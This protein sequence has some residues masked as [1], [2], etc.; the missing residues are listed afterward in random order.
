VD[1]VHDCDD[2]DCDVGVS[3]ECVRDGVAG[4]A[5]M[6][7]NSRNGCVIDCE[8]ENDLHHQKTHIWAL[9]VKGRLGKWCGIGMGSS[10]SSS[11]SRRSDKKKGAAKDLIGGST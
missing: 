6:R 2:D 4:D 10:S 1:E 5:E 3:G 7:P 9:V 11:S 8:D